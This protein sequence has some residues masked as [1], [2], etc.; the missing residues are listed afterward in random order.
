MFRA[1]ELA[2][3]TG[4]SG[5]IGGGKLKGVMEIWGTWPGKVEGFDGGS[6]ENCQ[7]N[8]HGI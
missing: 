2:G 3:K 6:R 5:E 7:G 4:E 8:T 1:R